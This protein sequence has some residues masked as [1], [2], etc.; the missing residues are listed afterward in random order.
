MGKW[1]WTRVIAAA[2]LYVAVVGVGRIAYATLRLEAAA[3]QAGM[4]LENTYLI[5]PPA[6]AWWPIV[7]VG[8]PVALLVWRA[9]RGAHRHGV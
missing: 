9:A 8:P 1:S 7:L 2:L 6:P 5:Q 4:D 3:K